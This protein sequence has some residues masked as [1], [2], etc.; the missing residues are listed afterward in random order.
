MLDIQKLEKSFGEKRAVQGLFRYREDREQFAHRHRLVAADEIQNP[1][2]RPAQA[3]FGEDPIGAR[4]E[5][6][7]TE[8]QQLDCLAQAGFVIYVRHI[9]ILV[10]AAYRVDKSTILTIIR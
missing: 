5:F 2:V 3:A 8:I 10:R 6:A 9:D 4:G 1:V 7:I